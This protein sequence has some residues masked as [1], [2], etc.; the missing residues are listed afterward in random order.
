MR[1]FA[2]HF[3]AHVLTFDYSGFGDSPGQPSE[4]QLSAD[5]EQMLAWVRNNIAS[6]TDVVLYGQSLGSFVAVELAA[7]VAGTGTL[8]A[9]VLDSAPA[10][11]LDA[12]LT[13]PIT[14]AFRII[15]NMRAY[16]ARIMH[17]RMDSIGRIGLVDVPILLVHGAQDWMITVEQGER[18]YETAKAAGNKHVEF[19]KFEGCGHNSVTSSA[20]YLSVVNAFFDRVLS[21]PVERGY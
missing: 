7:R 19:V 13:H 9:M 3:R 17:E 2:A 20:Q 12:A 1:L 4:Q 21:V 6:D 10:S 14:W 8:R 5:A 18:L 11:L 15:P 16:L